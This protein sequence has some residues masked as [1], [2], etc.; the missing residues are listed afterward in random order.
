M[1]YTKNRLFAKY[2]HECE[3]TYTVDEMPMFIP[4]TNLTV[5]FLRK[6]IKMRM[7]S[8]VNRR[9]NY[10]LRSQGAIAHEHYRHLKHLYMIHPFSD[11]RIIWEIIMM[12]V[13]LYSFV[14]IPMDILAHIFNVLMTFNS[15]VSWKIH[16]TIG[17]VMGLFD[18]GL[19]FITGYYDN[20]S[21]EVVLEPGKVCVHYLRTYF[22]FDLISSIPTHVEIGGQPTITLVLHYVSFLKMVRFITFRRFC[23]HFAE[24]FDIN[25]VT[26]RIFLAV[27]TLILFYHLICCFLLF[28]FGMIFYIDEEMIY[29]YKENEKTLVTSGYFNTM[30]ITT[31]LICAAGFNSVMEFNLFKV[32]V[33]FV[34]IVSKILYIYLLA[35]IIEVVTAKTSSSHKYVELVR[36][37]KEYMR[38]KQLPEYMQKRLLC[39][40]E[41]RFQ[42]T[43]FRESEILNTVSGQLRQEIVMHSCRKLVENVGFFRNL[44]LTLLVRIVSCLNLEI[45]LVNDVIVRANTPGDSMYFISSGTVAVYTKTGK[46]VCH[47]E[48]GAHFGEI[49]LVMNDEM[50]IASVVAVEIC[51]LYMLERKDFVRAI[52]PYPDLL[53]TVTYIAADRLERTSIIDE[54][55]KR[56]M[57]GRRMYNI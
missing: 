24:T 9:G 53:N 34:W 23:E 50:R 2:G 29:M 42:K 32:I 25:F 10:Y 51:E 6:L 39:Y 57:A 47:L 37:L 26:Y 55:N 43:Y 27:G 14:T 7:A 41:F 4:S 15:H 33:I 1:L 40:Y 36:Q 17:D 48:D 12:I 44:P 13:Y 49:A 30:Y 22:L 31:L 5:R 8:E 35:K 46:E 54:H 18:C 19:N 52:Y 20:K 16:R 21:K 11:I 28:I 3:I 45:F 38:H 56:E